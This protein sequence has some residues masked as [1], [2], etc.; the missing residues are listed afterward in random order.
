MKRFVLLITFLLSLST[1]VKAQNQ[2]IQNYKHTFQTAYQACPDIPRGL[3]EAISFTNTHCNHL[4]DDNYFHDGPDAMPRA[5]G[6]ALALTDE[7][8]KTWDAAKTACNTTK[9][10]STPVTGAT[11]LLASQ[12]QWQKMIDAA[13]SYTALRDGFSSVGGSNLKSD[14]YWSS[15]E[16]GSNKAMRYALDMHNWLGILRTN[17]AYVR[18]CLAF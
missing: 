12:D 7:G 3:L 13:G 15:T 8:K 16:S 6:L 4:T 17:P 14:N 5:Y 18:A 10:T 11:W 2:V 9:N 1:F